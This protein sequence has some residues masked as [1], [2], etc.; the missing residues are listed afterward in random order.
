MF[1]QYKCSVHK[2]Y[3]EFLKTEIWVVIL[4]VQWTHFSSPAIKWG[5]ENFTLV[6]D[7]MHTYLCIY[8]QFIH[9]MKSVTR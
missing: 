7:E 6:K 4:D 3:F 9:L 2:P 8:V 5:E 1:T